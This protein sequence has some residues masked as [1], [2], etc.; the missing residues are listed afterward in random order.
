[1]IECD[2]YRVFITSGGISVVGDG[3]DFTLPPGKVSDRVLA[4][5]GR[6]SPKRL[7]ELAKLAVKEYKAWAKRPLKWLT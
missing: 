3:W 5:V 6:M 7:Q 4:Q 2:G 1:M